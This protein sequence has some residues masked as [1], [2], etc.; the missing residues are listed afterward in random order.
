MYCDKIYFLDSFLKMKFYYLF[1]KLQ[2]SDS[3]AGNKKLL[4]IYIKYIMT[5]KLKNI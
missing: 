2:L 5:M 1:T 3:Y 4:D